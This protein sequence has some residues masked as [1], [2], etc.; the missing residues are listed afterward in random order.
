VKA[1]RAAPSIREPG[2]VQPPAP[3]TKKVDKKR[4]A[5]VDKIKRKVDKIAKAG[6]PSTTGKP[7]V[8]AGIS[9]QAWYKRKAKGTG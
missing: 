6:R 7:W 3:E 1:R 2:E 9:R 5:K 8:A 4:A